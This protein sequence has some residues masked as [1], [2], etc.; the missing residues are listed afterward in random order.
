MCFSPFSL[1]WSYCFLE[2]NSSY[3]WYHG[4]NV[5]WHDHRPRDFRKAWKGSSF[6]NLIFNM[7][8]KVYQFYGVTISKGYL[9]GK[10]TP[11][12]LRFVGIYSDYMNQTTREKSIKKISIVY[13][14]CL[15]KKW[16]MWKCIILTKDTLLNKDG[17]VSPKKWNGSR[18]D[19]TD[20]KT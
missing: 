7:R 11:Q 20:L 6:D 9:W 19:V 17:Q 13:T 1:L 15:K 12:K 3:V 18:D 16:C 8:H 4:H 10:I 2:T 5:H 14:A